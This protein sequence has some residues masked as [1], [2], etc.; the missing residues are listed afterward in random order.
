MVGS[1]G[2][3]AS[4]RGVAYGASWLLGWPF[5]GDAIDRTAEEGVTPLETFYSYSSHQL[6][7]LK[8]MVVEVR[9]AAPHAARSHAVPPAA[10]RRG[11][12]T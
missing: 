9:A 1:G 3:N 5:C 2:Q 4:A 12:S 11:R 6:L 8:K 10:R 7:E